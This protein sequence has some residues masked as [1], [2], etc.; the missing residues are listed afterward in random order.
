MT[1]TLKDIAKQAGVSIATVSRVLNKR[2][3]G[4][5]VSEETQQRIFSIA[6]DLGY[7]PNL[8]ARGLRSNHSSLIGVLVRDIADPFMSE[9]V[10]GINSISVKRGYRLFLGHV[11][12][13]SNAID[14][15]MMFEHSHA[16][17]ILILGDLKEDENAIEYLTSKNRYV[18]GVVDRITRRQYPGVYMDNVMGTRLALDHLWELG[19][20]E[21][22]CV[23]EHGA[24]DRR[25]RVQTYEQWMTDHGLINSIQVL[26]TLHSLRAAFE[27]GMEIFA[28]QSLPTAVFALTDRIAMGLLQAAFHARISVPDQLSIV[29]YD[30]LEFAEFLT[31]PLTT[32][33]QSPFE[34]GHAAANLLLDM[35]EQE[36]DSAIINDLV[37]SPELVIRQSTAPIRA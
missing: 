12:Q 15:G 30:N 19:H 29:G 6:A 31:P 26:P 35:I 24:Y 4:K 17:G 16:D 8:L 32:I 9:I 1:I 22:Y 5:F 23:S 7:R 20:R 27:V 37:L 28:S 18:V 21:I 36:L 33:N 13:V 25:L 14:Y 34:M 11:E 3:V 2:D 10:K